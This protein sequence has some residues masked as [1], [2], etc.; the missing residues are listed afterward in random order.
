MTSVA[1][2]KLV[3]ITV[4][5]A[6]GLLLSSCA[7]KI[8]EVPP[9]IYWPLPPEKPRIKF[10]DMIVGSKDVQ[11]R[12]RLANASSFL[13]GEGGEIKFVKPYGVAA[14]KNKL[15]ITDIGGVF[16]FDFESG[17]F[18]ILGS[19]QLRLPS[20]IAVT[21]NSFFVADTA[22]RKI[23]RYDLAG[24]LLRDFGG[25]EIGS[26]AGIAVDEKQKL[27]VVSDAK[28]HVV[29]LYDYEGKYL[30]HFGGRGSGKGEFNIPYGVAVDSSSRV[31]V[32]DSGNFR[33][34]IFDAQG[35]FI[36]SIGNVG[37]SA[38]NFARPKGV[39]LDSEGH[40][41]VLDAAF[42]NFQ[43]F[44]F[45]GQ[46]LLAVGANGTGPAEFRLP[47]SLFI[48]E[49]DKVYVVDQINTRVQIFQYLK[50]TQPR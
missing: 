9:E 5:L 14:R 3:L 38:G 41:Y 47:S 27:L 8:A 50:D 2:K 31:Y 18:S 4:V 22:S 17:K 13:F 37:S 16:V 30:R 29:H 32:V 24:G 40:I 28:K 46:S 20:G 19:K 25:S 39:A 35:V 6:S 45:D 26:I 43:I 7:Q 33:I 36:K 44:D 10:V 48:D 23:L 49:Y 12:D 21:E 34:Q 15:Y 1:W 42:G 11:K